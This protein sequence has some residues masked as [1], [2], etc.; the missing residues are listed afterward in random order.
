MGV[1][2][3]EFTHPPSFSRILTRFVVA[4]TKA[5]CNARISKKSLPALLDYRRSLLISFGNFA[6]SY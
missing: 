5:I 2:V 1:Y 4:L 3:S 6:Q